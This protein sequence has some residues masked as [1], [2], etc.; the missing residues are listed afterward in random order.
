MGDTTQSS[1]AWELQAE[2][3]P[4]TRYLVTVDSGLTDIFGQR[5][6][7][8]FTKSFGTTSYTP[9]V[10]YPYGRMVVEREGPRTLAVQHVNVDSLTVT[11]VGVPDS[12]EAKILGNEGSWG[13]VWEQLKGQA[14]VA[15]IPV[16]ATQDVPKVSA[17][18]IPAL[19]A[20]RAGNATLQMIRISSPS[21]DTTN[22]RNTSTA[23][24]QLTDL[25]V[26]ARIG[27]EEGVVWVTGVSDGLPRRGAR[28]TLYDNEGKTRASAM[29][30]RAG[31]G[32][33][34]R[35]RARHGADASGRR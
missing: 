35:L 25:A 9:Q 23:V 11:I 17:I 8:R 18:R 31:S 20:A 19:N 30:R 21:L 1:A 14:T 22:E 28:V 12:L 4:R 6:T 33:P 13:D 7:A 10:R 29:S 34:H 15:M 27:A 2:L 3:K 24:V 5:L 26:H 16:R 32:A